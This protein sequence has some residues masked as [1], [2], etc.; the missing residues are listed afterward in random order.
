MMP[1]LV[2]IGQQGLILAP[3]AEQRGAELRELLKVTPN[4]T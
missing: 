3:L 4:T 2:A 1:R